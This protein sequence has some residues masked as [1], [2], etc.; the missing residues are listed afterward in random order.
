MSDFQFS[1]SE[2]GF[3][4]VLVVIAVVVGVGVGD[5]DD[6]DD[7]D[8]VVDSFLRIT[9]NRVLFPFLSLISFAKTSSPNS[10]AAMKL[11]NAADSPLLS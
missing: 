4:V 6:D 2:F 8:V 3:A 5:D 11:D 1:P 9:K 7:D 10:S